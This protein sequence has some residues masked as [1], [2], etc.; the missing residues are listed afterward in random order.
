MVKLKDIKMKPKLMGLFL[1]IGLIPLSIV[2]YWSS[3]LATQAL[4]E[5]SYGQLQAVREIKRAQIEKYFTER[6]GD[7]AVLV[8]T[9]QTL[10]EEAFGQLSTVQQ[11]KSGQLEDY[12]SER[13]GDVRVLAA[14]EG[15]SGAL[16]DYAEAFNQ[17]NGQTGGPL[18]KAADGKWGPWLEQYKQEYGYYDLFLIDKQGDVVYTVERESDLGANLASGALKD[19]PLAHCFEKALQGVAIQD[20]E[21]YAPSGGQFSAFVGAP[22]LR[23]GQLAGVVALQLPTGPVNAIVQKRQGMGRTGETYLV[24]KHNGKTAFRSDLTTMGD[25][26]YVIGHGIS[27]PYIEAALNGEKG[28]ET[29]TDTNGKLVMVVYNPLDISGLN[30]ASISKIDLEEAIAPKRQGAEKDFFANYIEKYGYYDLFLVHPKGEVFYTVTKEADYGTNMVDGIYADSGLG[31]LVRKVLESGRFGLADFEPYAPSGGVPASFIARPVMKNGKPQLVVALQMPLKAINSIM[32]ER[33]GMGESGET[34]LVGSDKLMRSDSFL[35]PTHHSV[36]ASF[37]DPSKGSVDTEAVR[38]ALSGQTDRKIIL[39]YNGNPVLSAYAPVHLEGV[40]WALLAEIDEAEVKEPIWKLVKSIL[41][42]GGILTAAV[43]LIALVVAGGIANPL[44]QG[45]AFA[46]AVAAGDLTAHIDVKQKD[47][48]GD[49]AQALRDMVSRLREIVGEVKSASTNVASGS[50]ELSSTAE[51]MSQ[52]AT[53]Q[54]SAVEEASSSME[55]MSAS[56]RQSADNAKQT[57]TIA[58]QSAG[59]A[60][61][62]GKAVTETV[63]AMREITEKIS[64]IEEI[65]RQTDLLALNAAIEAARAGEHGKGFA[66][67]ASEVRKLAERSRTAAGQINQLSV[68]SLDVAERAG[69]MLEELVPEIKRTADLVQEIAAASGEQSSGAEQVNQAI[70][71]LDQV[72]QQNAAASEEMASAS[73][74]LSGQAEQLQGTMSFFKTDATTLTARAVRPDKGK[75]QAKTSKR[76]GARKLPGT[77]GGGYLLDMSEGSGTGD[78]QDTEFERY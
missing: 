71:Q 37:K 54:A 2:G 66:V 75:S 59:S 8:E 30:W 62:S 60:E 48:I 15:V 17:E 22:V 67:V 69:K 61:E 35:D 42:A 49:L 24:G 46:K 39:D 6:Q 13:L 65:A 28:S 26:K 47:E 10:M 32:Q 36:L 4:M 14:N 77:E 41:V 44:V 40:T 50:E 34:Y 70:Q 51:E 5:K 55:E 76:E 18:W 23:E 11:L 29:Y 7:M 78:G 25:G 27:T 57:E 45:V 12:F 31:K 16:H 19:S 9:V 3:H 63:T 74:E 20:F 68:S 38:E 1:L 52:G 43:I 53:E 33:E 72:I 58:L 64:I 56:I 73:E 21:P